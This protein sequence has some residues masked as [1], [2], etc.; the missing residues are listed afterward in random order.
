[1]ST[2]GTIRFPEIATPDTPPTDQ[3][4]VYVGTDGSLKKVND[5]GSV[6]TYGSGSG[7]VVGPGGGSTDNAVARFDSTTGQLIQNSGVI[8]DD[9]NNVT[10]VVN[11]TTTGHIIIEDQ[12]ELRLNDSAGTEYVG[13]KSPASLSATYTLTLPGDDGS[14]GEVLTTNGSGVLSWATA[15]SGSGDVVGPSSAVASE[16]VLFDGTTGKLVKSATGSGIV[17]ATS[18]VYSTVT[19]PSGTIVGT[20][21]SQSL[22]NKTLDNTTTATIKDTLF[23]IQDDGDATK[24]IAFQASSITTGT[25]R[26]LTVPDASGIITLTAA[27]QTLT[28]KTLTTPTIADFTNAG[29]DHSNAAGG[30]TILA[31]AVSNFDEAAQDAV[32]AMI[33][34]S[35]TY[36]DGTPL[37]Q[38][39]AL[40][41]DV[42]ASAGSNTTTIAN[43]AVTNA[44]A[45]NMA[46]STIK[47]RA[48]S[49][50]TGDPTDLTATQA[51][52]IL[53]AF[54][55]D[56]GSGGTKGLV[57]APTTGD[58][59]KFLKGDGT[60]ATGG[61][62][63]ATIQEEGSNL[64]VRATLNFIGA[65]VTAADDSGN[66]RTNVT[67][68]QSPSG[69]TSVVGTG[70]SIATTSPLSGGG[71]LSADRTIAM[72]AAA[73][74]TAGYVTT[75]SQTLDGKKT[76]TNGAIMS[77]SF[78]MSPVALTDAATVATDASLGNSFRVTLA[79][80]RTLGN[81][82]NPTDGQRAIW[83]IIQDA[84][85]SRTITLDTKFALGSDIFSVVLS[86]AP[87]KRDF[88]GAYYNSTADKW[89]VIA[90]V[91]GY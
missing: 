19:A 27:T 29:H 55:G 41:G 84:T 72:S 91:K 45:A 17:K 59:T 37:L 82:T 26:T 81:P 70:R 34:S 63:Y 6:T 74:G 57:P 50:G 83:E 48:V 79:G 90:F 56:S 73:S 25:T 67:L 35:L 21:D 80:N 39:A 9:S 78:I 3:H 64:T 31:A 62:G 65:S 66:T 10:G 51:T 85:G 4:R 69:S 58:A 11:L 71:D 44:K 8:I 28:N 46:Q 30:G 68:S 2:D 16:I 43:D 88:L 89:Y 53:D 36:V 52:A 87:S 76:F 23:T 38:R 7:D 15:S 13:I 33:D 14:S 12:K 86:T 22:S 77:A 32:G 42:T 24:L 75:G 47:G 60:W 5:A 18:G 49:A 1:M 54:V 40:T 20:S 61:S